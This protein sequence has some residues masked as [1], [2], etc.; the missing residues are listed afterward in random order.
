MHDCQFQITGFRQGNKLFRLMRRKRE[1][2]LYQNMLA[3]FKREPNQRGMS[4]RIGS[5]DDGFTHIH[6]PWNILSGP[7]KRMRN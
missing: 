1:R 3:L 6:S 2:L 4:G 7:D 5:D